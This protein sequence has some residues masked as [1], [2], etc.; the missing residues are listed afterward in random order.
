MVR[1]VGVDESLGL[2]DGD[3]LFEFT[4]E[5]SSVHIHEVEFQVLNDCDGDDN[6]EASVPGWCKGLIVV[7][8][9]LL[10]EALGDISGLKSV[11]RPICIQL[12]PVDLEFMAVLS[13][14]LPQGGLG[15]QN[16]LKVWWD[17]DLPL[18][19]SSFFGSHEQDTLCALQ[20]ANSTRW[21]GDGGFTALQEEE[22]L[23]R[24]PPGEPLP[25]C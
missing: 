3:L 19:E 4:I 18:G 13:G 1:I 25:L 21:G 8:A 7:D 17:S 12:Q 16:A 5:E 9:F 20:D 24:I 2:S 23:R 22:W 6:L 10:S 11:D 15:V 14:G